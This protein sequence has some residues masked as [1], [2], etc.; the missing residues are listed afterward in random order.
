LRIF[1][2][3]YDEQR[4]VVTPEFVSAVVQPQAATVEAIVRQLLPVVAENVVP[5]IERLAAVILD[6]NRDTGET[7]KMPDWETLIRLVNVELPER[8]VFPELP[9]AYDL[10]QVLAYLDQ[11]IQESGVKLQDLIAVIQLAE[12][13]KVG[14]PREVVLLLLRLAFPGEAF[15]RK[16][17]SLGGYVA[18][19]ESEFIELAAKV[20]GYFDPGFVNKTDA[21][22]LIY[23][24]GDELPSWEDLSPFLFLLK[25]N[26]KFHVRIVLYDSVD[27]EAAIA[28]ADRARE[29]YDLEGKP[30]G[31]RFDIVE[32]SE[33]E[34]ATF[35]ETLPFRRFDLGHPQ[36]RDKET[37]QEQVRTASLGKV[38]TQSDFL[39][40]S[41]FFSEEDGLLRIM[42]R[43]PGTAWLVYDPIP[44]REVRRPYTLLRL[45][46]AALLR[47]DLDD[48]AMREFV[49]QRK[50]GLM[51]F[52]PN[53]EAL[54]QFLSIW[55]KNMRKLLAAA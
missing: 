19:S 25:L 44:G 16:L 15:G 7:P 54:A 14:L 30:I 45:T 17:E 24:W 22:A 46:Q 23:N 13:A 26:T 10:S 53:A 55:G 29:L 32:T 4:E 2:S 20:Y 9:G 11:V 43:L 41:V 1:I 12:G 31:T 27:R 18:A 39:R 28:L 50:S 47:D 8:P 42:R 3:L 51:R 21:G 35:M 33:E 5:V 48:D 36:G 49:L 52:K 34:A 40:H 37:L 6:I 38:K